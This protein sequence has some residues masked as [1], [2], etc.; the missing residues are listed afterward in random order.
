MTAESTGPLSGL[1][2]VDLTAFASGPLATSVLADQGADV[3]KVERIDGGDGMRSLGASVNGVSPIFATLNRNKRSIAVDL[4]TTAGVALVRRLAA[5]ADAFVENLR[6]GV[7]D[8]LGLGEPDLRSADPSLV[9]AS[10]SG[11]GDAGPYADRPAYDA[12][13]QATSGVVAHQGQLADG[14]E[15]HFV[16]S[17]LCDK[18][19]GMSAAQLVTAALLARARGLGGQHVKVSMLHASLHFMWSDGMQD[20]AFLEPG[21]TSAPKATQPPVRRTADGYIAVSTTKDDEFRRFCGA[22]G[23]GALADDP[24]FGMSR[25]RFRHTDA[26]TALLDPIVAGITTADLV[27]R[28]T[29]ADV[30]HA[31]VTAL[32]RI[33][34]HEQV[35]HLGMLTEVDQSPGGTMRQPTPVGSFSATPTAVR[36]PAPALGE[37]TDAVLAEMGIDEGD[38]ARLRVDRVVA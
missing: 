31:V 30:A 35:Q 15:P 8:R 7:T 5:S 34:E 27:D 38:R 24:R 19:T 28:L 21:P 18:V 22:L 32:D 1:R 4:K 25:E 13:M 14:G 37:H 11:F 9:Y 17:A 23:A 29:A 20:V 16:R 6:P 3:I 36:S 26:L 2:V 10:I 12:V 33:H